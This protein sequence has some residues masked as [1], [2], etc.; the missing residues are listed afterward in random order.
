[1][2]AGRPGQTVQCT[3][4]EYHSSRDETSRRIVAFLLILGILF[5][6]DIATTQIILHMGGIELNPFMAGI[7]ANPALHLCIKAAILL[8]IFPVSLIAEKRVKGSGALF[9]GVLITLY[10]V[11]LIN[12]L[13]V[14]VPQIRL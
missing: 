7:V 3:L 11:V 6:L 5:L 12:N 14:I 2:F 10:I 4:P 13:A 1:M 9:Y 8:V